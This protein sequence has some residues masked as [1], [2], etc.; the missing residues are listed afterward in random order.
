MFPGEM[1]LSMYFIHSDY[2]TIQCTSNPRHKTPSKLEN[3]LIWSIWRKDLDSNDQ[4]QHVVCVVLNP[5]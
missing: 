3:I 4:L 5:K 1:N 2:A